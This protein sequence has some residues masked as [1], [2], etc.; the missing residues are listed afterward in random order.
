M[1]K[2]KTETNVK[3]AKPRSRKGK[4]KGKDKAHGPKL[5]DLKSKYERALKKKSWV[6]EKKKVARK[7]TKP[8]AVRDT[9]APR[10]TVSKGQK[11]KKDEEEEE[12]D[13]DA[14]DGVQT[15]D[16]EAEENQQ[17]AAESRSTQLHIAS[18]LGRGFDD[19]T[20]D[21][22]FSLLDQEESGTLS[23]AD[24]RER[25]VKHFQMRKEQ[26][27]RNVVNTVLAGFVNCLCPTLGID[28][29]T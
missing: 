1:P 16:E 26:D 22:L 7:V 12:D 11:K 20:A 5:S 9:S 28:Y 14:E 2:A 27:A 8:R 19:T 4:A 21:S 18:R 25:Y 13:V 29:W 17:R 6:P 23:V 10:S 15:V 3:A 24:I